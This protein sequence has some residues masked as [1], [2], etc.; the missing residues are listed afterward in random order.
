MNLRYKV[1]QLNFFHW[2]F[3]I[4]IAA[5][6]AFNFSTGQKNEN[7]HRETVILPPNLMSIILINSAEYLEYL[8]RIERTLNAKDVCS[9]LGPFKKQEDVDFLQ[10]HL[11]QK[12]FDVAVRTSNEREVAGY[13]IYLTPERSRA[14]GRLKVEEI[15]LKG[16]KDVVL[17]TNDN[18]I[19]AISLGFFK[20]TI[21]ANRRLMKAQSLGLEAK[22]QTRYKNHDYRWI[23]LKVSKRDDLPQREWLNILRDYEGVELKTESCE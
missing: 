11:S 23:S 9:T 18:P 12:N 5:N 20:D 19:N 3:I 1:K 13:W 8:A 17:L 4:L 21:F 7:M 10:A 14:L 16:L 15:K 6:I 22:M 2:I